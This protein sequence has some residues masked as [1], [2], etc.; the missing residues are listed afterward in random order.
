MGRAGASPLREDRLGHPGRRPQPGRGKGEAIQPGPKKRLGQAQNRQG[1]LGPARFTRDEVRDV[2][3]SL[4]ALDQ[5]RDIAQPERAQH[6]VPD[7]VDAD[8][9]KV[10]LGTE[11]TD[12][13]TLHHFDPRSS[14]DLRLAS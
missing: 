7:R 11:K 10:V 9:A 1:R 2:K 12:P 5:K 4:Q 3:T 14:M 13:H 6:A 8:E